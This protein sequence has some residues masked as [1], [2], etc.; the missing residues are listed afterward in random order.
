MVI[1]N[2]KMV[3]KHG[4]CSIFL[5]ELEISGAAIQSIHQNNENW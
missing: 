2:G 5:L 1:R 3:W 4:P